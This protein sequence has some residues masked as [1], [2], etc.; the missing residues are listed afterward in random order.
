MNFNELSD[1][2]LA[3]PVIKSKLAEALRR[4]MLDKIVSMTDSISLR[5]WICQW[6]QHGSR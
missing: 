3:D 2:I 5:N 6:D 4:V 1:K